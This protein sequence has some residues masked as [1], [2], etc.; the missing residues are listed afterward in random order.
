[1]GRFVIAAYR[2][3][4]GREPQLL[5]AVARHMPVLRDADGKVVEVFEWL[6]P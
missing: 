5:A 3:K 1:M 6:S 2:L 4:R